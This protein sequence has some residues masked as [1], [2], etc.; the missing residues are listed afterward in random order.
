M[1]ESCPERLGRISFVVGHEEYGRL[2]EKLTLLV[3]CW[4]NVR[5]ASNKD[6]KIQ[7]VLGDEPE[8]PIGHGAMFRKRRS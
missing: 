5:H 7:E 3:L 8:H 6:V 4:R 1:A 2:R